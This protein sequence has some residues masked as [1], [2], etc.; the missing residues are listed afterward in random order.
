MNNENR[1]P[2]WDNLFRDQCSGGIGSNAKVYHD[3]SKAK[4]HIGKVNKANANPTMLQAPKSIVTARDVPTKDRASWN[5]GKV[6]LKTG[7]GG[8]PRSK[9]H[10]SNIGCL[11][12]HRGAP[13]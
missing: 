11:N 3:P 5:R 8:G 9:Q 10:I 7:I 13:Q 12:A 1:A 6:G 2:Q 4:R